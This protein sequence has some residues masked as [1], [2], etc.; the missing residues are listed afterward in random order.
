MEEA[1]SKGGSQDILVFLGYFMD[2][3][4]CT[5]TDDGDVGY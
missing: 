2:L 5:G 1:R 3:A 4:V